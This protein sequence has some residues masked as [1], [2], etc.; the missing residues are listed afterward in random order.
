MIKALGILTCAVALGVAS[1]ICVA[2]GQND[3]SSAS[4]VTVHMRNMAFDPQSTKVQAGQT[5]VFQNDDTVSHNVTSSD[6]GTSG[7]IR[8]GKTWKYKFDKAG[9]FHYVCT[10]HQGMAGEII[11]GESK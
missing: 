9:D 8:P 11:V 4:T 10:Y 1:S 3:Q 6:I 5:V 7:D 2:F